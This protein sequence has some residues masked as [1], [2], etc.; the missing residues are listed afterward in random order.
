MN[1]LPEFTI[2]AADSEIAHFRVAVQV[3]HQS[4][5]RL[6]AVLALVDTGSTYTWIPRDVLDGL[7]VAP[8]EE[9]PFV[10]ADGREVRYGRVDQ[11]EDRRSSPA[12]DR[13]V[14]PAWVGADFGGVRPRGLPVRR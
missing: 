2:P 8:E 5:G 14:R 9:W 12:H 1:W 11:D 13:C 7:G 3:G 10:L 4:G 6:V